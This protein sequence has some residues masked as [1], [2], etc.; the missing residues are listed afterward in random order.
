MLRP[1]RRPPREPDSMRSPGMP[2]PREKEARQEFFDALYRT[3]QE[4]WDYSRNAAELLRHDLVVRTTRAFT[5][6]HPDARVLD[7]GCSLGQ[8]TA[9]LAGLAAEV[10]AIDL[11]AAAVAEARERCARASAAAA[12]RPS[13][14]HFYV[15]SVTQLPFA[16]ASF[17]VL[18]M[19]DGLV[20]G[21]SWGLTPE[22][23]KVAL[24]QA[25]R[26]TAPGGRVIL[27]D[28]LKPHQIAG[29]VE[30]VEESPFEVAAMRL[31]HDRLW[32]SVDRA[33][34][35]IRDWRLPRAALA[36]RGVARLLMA[37]S[38]LGGRRGSKHVLILARKPEAAA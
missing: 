25:Y 20:G 1:K 31:I 29:F 24:E 21:H 32:Y 17:D 6:G 36:S 9:R 16:P 22:E 2:E 11:S 35:P 30:R 10:H 38:R 7:V 27:T 33:A 34:R 26:V 15:G 37:L 28:A 12:G 13:S 19:C 4:P 14:F 3:R 18:L 5:A 8:L 23:Q